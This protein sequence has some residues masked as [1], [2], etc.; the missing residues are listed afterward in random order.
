MLAMW[1]TL[2]WQLA[3]SNRASQEGDSLLATWKEAALLCHPVSDVPSFSIDSIWLAEA[4]PRLHP[5]SGNTWRWDPEIILE[6]FQSHTGTYQRHLSRGWH[7]L[8]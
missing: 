7:I 6:I 4:S 2:S 8:I 5:R 3:P 1:A